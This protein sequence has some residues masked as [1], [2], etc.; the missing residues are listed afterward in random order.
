VP[1]CKPEK[2]E[3]C[4]ELSP[5]QWATHTISH[6]APEGPIPNLD[7]LLLFD[8]S[9]SMS[10]PINSVRENA[11]EIMAK[12]REE[13]PDAAFGVAS[14]TDYP[15]AYEYEG[16]V[17][18]YGDPNDNDYPW[19]LDQDITTDADAVQQSLDSLE[20]ARLGEDMPESYTR[21]LRETLDLSWR[22]GAK[23][24]VVLF[25]DSVP[26]D[27]DFFMAD[28]NRDTGVD[29]G[30]DNDAGTGDDLDYDEVVQWLKE[31]E[32]E[33]IAI[34]C[35]PLEDRDYSMVEASFN[36]VANETGGQVYAL[37]HAADAPETVVSG[38]KAATKQYNRLTVVPDHV[39]VGPWVW[40]EP[41][42]YEGVGSGESRS[43]V[44]TITVPEGT[45]PEVYEFDLTVQ[46][47]GL[48]LE[49]F[50]VV[51]YVR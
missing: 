35:T 15:G 28:F 30:R 21:A 31:Q 43:F 37:A 38:L 13:V 19:N 17:R 32:I 6:T 42:F 36:H 39:P 50:P 18:Q 40:A 8:A 5:G 23:K 7:V 33:V 25:G 14:F 34:N 41:W 20:P 22:P 9:A 12:V 10:G 44:V 48:P 11:L 51:V 2:K 46:G 45:W 26:H 16:H 24:V 4:L 1:P 3:I 29:P 49:M 47:D 27:T